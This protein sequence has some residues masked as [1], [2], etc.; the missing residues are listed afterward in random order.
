MDTVMQDVSNLDTIIYNISNPDTCQG[1]IWNGRPDPAHFIRGK[2]S[3]T[4]T[5]RR[6][7]RWENVKKLFLFQ[8][9]THYVT[10]Q[11]VK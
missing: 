11:G 10:I 7:R 5:S 8:Y 9:V 6:E 3:R 2:G 4:C 1:T